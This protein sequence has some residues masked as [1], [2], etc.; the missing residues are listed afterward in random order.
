MPRPE[1]LSPAEMEELERAKERVGRGK[2]GDG[3]SRSGRAKSTGSSHD[4]L[5]ASVTFFFGACIATFLFFA[6]PYL[7]SFETYR[8]VNCGLLFWLPYM[9]ITFFLKPDVQQF[10]LT[11][12]DLRFGLRAVGLGL[13]PMI[14]VLV[15]VSLQPNFRDYYGNA[16]AQPLGIADYAARAYWNPQVKSLGLIYYELGQGFYF[17]CW[18]FFFRGFLLFGLSRAKRVGSAGAVI[19]QAI[20]FATLH[21]SIVPGASKPP[22]EIASALVGGLILGWLALRTRTFLYGFVIHWAISI[23]LDLLLVFSLFAHPL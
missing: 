9:V 11:R 2:R 21:W 7:G 18:E 16:L 4:G 13:L 20:V 22:L 15:I 17:F 14:F 8:L 5:V 12:G 23:I 3:P 19:L 6:N 1:A 10:G